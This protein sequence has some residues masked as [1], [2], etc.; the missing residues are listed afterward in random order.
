MLANGRNAKMM[1]PATLKMALA[2]QANIDYHV[3]FE[4]HYYSVPYQLRGE[5][6][7]LRATATTMNTSIMPMRA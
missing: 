7:A 6:L 5:V 2:K 4:D 3:A 1:S